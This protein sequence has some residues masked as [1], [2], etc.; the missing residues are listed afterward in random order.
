MSEKKDI[1]LLQ[2]G[3]LWGS[4][5]VAVQNAVVQVFAQIG[6][7]DWAEPYKIENEY[8]NRGSGFLIDDQGYLI[9]NAHVVEDAKHLWVHIPLLGH[10]PLEAHIVGICPDRDLAL[11]KI[12]DVDVASIREKIGGIPFLALGDSDYIQATDSILSLGYPLGQYHLKSTT[13]VVSGREQVYG[14]SLLQV[15]TPV[16]PGSSGGPLLNIRGQVIGITIA[17]VPLAQNVGYAIPV[18]ELHMVIQDLYS[19]RFVRKPLLGARFVY[20]GDEKARL[21]NNPYPCGIY[22]AKV[23]KGSLLEKAGVQDGDMLYSLNGLSLDP[24]GET[25]VPWSLSRL[26]LYDL[27]S[28]IKIGEKVDL[29]IYR[30]GQKKEISFVMQNIYPFAVRRK[31]PGFED[32][33]YDVLAGMI[34]M[35]LADDH[36][37]LLLPTAPELIRYSQYENR[38]D[39]VLVIA[40]ILPGSYTHQLGMLAPGNIIT[41]VNGKQ[42][43]TLDDWKRAVSVNT[44]NDLISLKTDMDVLV[45]F[46]LEKILKDEVRLSEAFAYPL[47]ETVKKLLH[48]AERKK[49]NKK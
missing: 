12:S 7:F 29:I 48:T 25:M 39:P 45:V 35:E 9:T 46:S 24:Y 27:I 32:I 37:P 47:S 4:I 14:Y 18:N 10:Q 28:R 33:G 21:L 31:F 34:I 11:V 2:E 36:L 41:Q 49:G 44:E 1:Y 19:N 38:V 40:H 15:T 8:E 16:N 23:Y 17:M 42:V 5:Q 43:A 3:A 13:G 26:S 30:N 22:I 6:S 20:A